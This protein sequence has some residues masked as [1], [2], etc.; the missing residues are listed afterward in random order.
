MD[1]LK[2]ILSSFPLSQFLTDAFDTTQPLWERLGN[3]VIFLGF[4]ALIIGFAL[5]SI[6]PGTGIGQ[7]IASIGGPLTYAAMIPMIF[8]IMLIEI[9]KYR[10]TRLH[11]SG[12]R[13]IS[14]FYGTVV[15]VLLPCM[16]LTVILMLVEA[17]LR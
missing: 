6:A 8:I 2:R 9:K 4:A 5:V 3:M 16:L 13:W 11:D 17:F 14:I 15:F 10:R 1:L 12:K 7:Q